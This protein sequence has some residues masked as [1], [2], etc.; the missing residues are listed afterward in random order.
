MPLM[1]AGGASLSLHS[2]QAAA[3][4]AAAS[5]SLVAIKAYLWSE[6]GKRQIGWVEDWHRNQVGALLWWAM[7]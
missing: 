4:G 6:H 7:R 3:L 1:H 2:L 5:L